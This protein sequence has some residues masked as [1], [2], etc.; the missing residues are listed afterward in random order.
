MFYERFLPPSDGSLVDEVAGDV[1]ATSVFIVVWYLTYRRL[2]IAVETEKTL[3]WI[4]TLASAVVGL[5]LCVGH[6]REAIRT[7]F[8]YDAVMGNDRDSRRIAVFFVTYFA[9]D[10]VLG[11]LHFPSQFGLLSGY[12][13]HGFF[14]FGLL[15]ALYWEYTKAFVVCLPAE[16]STLPLGLGHCH[17][18]LRNDILFGVVFFAVRIVYIGV[19]VWK[20]LVVRPFSWVFLA[21][22]VPWVMHWYWFSAWFK[23][24][25]PGRRKK[26]KTA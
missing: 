1:T 19:V 25:A 6:V 2:F 11:Q 8:A 3:A 10:M 18:A 15:A 4:M 5:A 7:D 26:P 14:G 17:K 21:G 12:F 22:L 20:L 13:H 9:W 24:Y 23:K 16:L